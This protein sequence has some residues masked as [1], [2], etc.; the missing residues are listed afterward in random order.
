MG[1][2]TDFIG[3]FEFSRELSVSEQKT[4]NDFADADHRDE[5]GMPGTY[6]QWITNGFSLEWD[7][8]EKF[9]DY[10]E[11]LEYLIEHYFSKWG[12]KLN[13]IVK[14]QG[15]EIGDVGRIEVKDNVVTLVE[16]EVTGEVECPNCGER[17]KPDE[18]NS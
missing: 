13:G 5:E 16:L 18:D 7:G 11:W 6:C 9:Y 10:V 8:N 17:F 3:E 4:I 2:Q 12:V 1:Y 15:E 14:Y